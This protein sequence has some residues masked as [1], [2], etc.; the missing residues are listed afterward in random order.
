MKIRLENA[1]AAQ[2][3]AFILAQWGVDTAA[4]ATVKSL[5]N[6]LAALGFEGEEFEISE[7]EVELA[8]TDLKEGIWTPDHAVAA[9][10]A[11]G[12]PESDARALIGL[13]EKGKAAE[14]VRKARARG[15][16]P[17]GPGKEHLYCTV[18][19]HAGSGKEGGWDVQTMVN[20]RRKDI[21]RAIDWPIPS[22][23]V[24]VL[25]H[26]IRIVYEEVFISPDLPRRHVPRAVRKYPYDLVAGPYDHDEYLRQSAIAAEALAH[27]RGKVVAPAQ[28]PEAMLAADMAAA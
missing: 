18:N 12:M 9:L 7:Q 19:L 1:T 14:S 2:L 23:F 11:G 4:N 26:T 10:I 16:K 28:S 6:K 13:A 25:D 3:R 24:E 17:Y 21:P 15:E 5:T 8:T 22:A 27:L 20:G